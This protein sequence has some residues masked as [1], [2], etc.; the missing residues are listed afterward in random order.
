LNLDKSQCP[1]F[2]A[3]WAGHVLPTLPKQPEVDYT[4]NYS[5]W[6]FGRFEAFH[7]A[8]LI[9]VPDRV[10]VWW[11]GV[12]AESV[13]HEVAST[14]V[15]FIPAVIENR[16][17]RGDHV[18]SVVG[19]VGAQAAGPSDRFGCPPGRCTAAFWADDLRRGWGNAARMLKV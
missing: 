8:L 7:Q 19:A 10:R 14:T 16:A 18:V 2:A 6:D 4:D 17:N 3:A 13:T 9:F 5:E 12:H 15:G 1:V 11:I